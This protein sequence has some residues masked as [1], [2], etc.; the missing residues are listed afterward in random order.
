MIYPKFI[1]EHDLIGVTAPS[2]GITERVK[3]KRL[4]NAIDNFKKLNFNIIE[5]PSVR[6]S[7]KGKSAPSK[8]QAEEL[9]SL[10]KNND[11]KMIFCASGG[12]FLLEILPFINFEIIK[13]N[14]K[15][16]QG[17]SDPTVLLYVITTKYDI[18][19]LYGNNFAAFGMKP[20]H[21][22]LNNNLAILKG[23]RLVE[24]SFLKYESTHTK[25][26]TGYESYNLDKEVK[27]EVL[28]ATKTEFEGRI[29]GGCLEILSEIFGTKFDNTL[30]FIN[31]YK[32]DGIIWYFDNAEKTSEDLIRILWR[33]K[34]TGWFKY[35]KGIIFG[36]SAKEE[37][38]YDISF[39]EAIEHSLNDLNIPIII[40]ADI[41]HI[42]PRITV[43][44]GAYAKVVSENGTGEITFILK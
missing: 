33:F 17:Y 9:E 38:Y 14:I 12:D 43:I 23:D 5:T 19:T 13:E 21:E 11:V 29:I 8:I 2:D 36:R 20:W 10:Y 27:W 4:D 25:Y 15:W 34:N 16:L 40:N 31:K 32:D 42:S 1:K 28:N 41:G 39:K 24:K 18:A 3:L 22:S 37:S 30:N 6:F 7:N 26:L 35:T 44:N